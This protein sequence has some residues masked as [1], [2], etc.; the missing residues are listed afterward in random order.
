M[1][2]YTVR[3]IGQNL[4][5]V[6]LVT[7]TTFF[8]VSQMPGNPLDQLLMNPEITPDQ[9]ANLKRIWGMDQNFAVRYV[10]WLGELA[11][12]ELGYSFRFRLPVSELLALRLPN[13]LILM[14]ASML[15]AMSLAL[16]IGV[17]SAVRQYSLSVPNHWLGLILIVLFSLHWRILPSAGFRSL[18]LPPTVWGVV[19]DRLKYLILPMIT[20]GISSMAGWMRY[21]RS[22]MLEVLR[23][24]YTQTARSKGLA[25]R[26]VIL[27]HALRNALIPVLTIFFMAIPG[28][29]SGAI[30]TEAVF[31]YPGMGRLYWE[32][33]LSKDL[34]VVSITFLI[35][36]LLV[37]FCNLAADLMYAVV[38]PRVRYD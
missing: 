38:D 1:I 3:R 5:V 20:I 16:P 37:A 31:A 29:F 34:P 15:L 14:G 28:L 25:E 23:Q 11:R 26:R 2:G 12:G 30:I 19:L 8:L 4:L 17:Y 36:A 10:G 9:V 35:I 18:T 13:T 32:A 21:T 7:F 27:V 24:D 33:L 6:L 22:S